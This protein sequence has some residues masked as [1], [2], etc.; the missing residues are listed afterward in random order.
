MS[1]CFVLGIL[2]GIYQ[3]VTM[4]EPIWWKPIICALTTGSIYVGMGLIANTILVQLLILP[5]PSVSLFVGFSCLA[6]GSAFGYGI[7]YAFDA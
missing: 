4:G 2:P 6:V 7:A 5:I 3:A 1:E